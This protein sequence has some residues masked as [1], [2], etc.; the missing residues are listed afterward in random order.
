M[1]DLQLHYR[2]LLLWYVNYF[3]FFYIKQSNVTVVENHPLI[4]NLTDSRGGL[5]SVPYL[6]CDWAEGHERAGSLKTAN[7]VL[8]HT[9]LVSR[10]GRGVYL[11]G[12]SRLLGQLKKEKR[13]PRQIFCL[14][15]KNEGNRASPSRTMR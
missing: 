2:I 4:T 8:I 9:N 13:L 7:S 6:S 10:A 15:N 11:Y 12:G 5:I 3:L 1:C 14:K